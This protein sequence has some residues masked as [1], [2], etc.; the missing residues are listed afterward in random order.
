VA[1][2]RTR[3]SAL[4]VAG[5]I[6]ATSCVVAGCFAY[7]QD[8]YLPKEVRIPDLPALTAKSRDA[9][10][11]LA[12]SVE[13]IFRDK[14]ICCGKNSALG[15]SV[16]SA[17]PK[18]LKDVSAKLQGRHLLS[19]GRPIMVTAD[20]VPA[21]SVNSGALIAALTEKRAPL[22]LWNSQLYVV[23]G[24][25]YVET[26]DSNSYGILDAIRTLS[27]LDTRF[28][29]ERRKVSFHRETD[30]WGKVQGMVMLKAAPQ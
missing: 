19:D 24:V 28:S 11:V 27:L 2:L 6:L 20:Y 22:M 29:D 10:D 16:Q 23:Y 14:D 30:D 8:Y 17:D 3:Q 18:S 4:L 12:A 1:N 26:V 7:A 13:I 15:D 21:A 5:T 25:T 9:S